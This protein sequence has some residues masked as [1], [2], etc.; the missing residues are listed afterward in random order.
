MSLDDFYLTLK[1]RKALSKQVTPLL[2]TRG[3]PGTHDVNLM[4]RIIADVC[5]NR[6]TQVPRFDKAIDDREQDLEI[7]DAGVDILIVEGW[8]LGATGYS[9]VRYS[10]TTTLRPCQYVRKYRRQ[11]L[12]MAKIC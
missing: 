10:A 11:G 3:V 1:E 5:A 7:V 6:Q 4:N 2:E 12:R 8:C 9:S